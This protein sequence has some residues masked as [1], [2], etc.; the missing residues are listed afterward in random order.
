[1]IQGTYHSRMGKVMR[2]VRKGTDMNRWSNRGNR[3]SNTWAIGIIVSGG[4]LLL[5]SCGSSTSTASTNS[6]PAQGA[7]PVRG[8]TI[9]V[10][11]VSDPPT[12]DWTSSTSTITYEVAWNIFE[13]LFAL[14]KNSN[15]KPMLATGYT[16][17][18]NGMN[19]TIGIRKGITFQ[20]GQSL[21]SADVVAS[22]KR[23]EAISSV[24]ET[25]A[26][27][28]ASVSAAGKYQVD[29]AMSTPFSPL[30]LD[31]AAPAQACIIIPASIVAAAGANPLTNAQIIGTGPYKLVNDLVGQKIELTRWSGY[32]PLPKADNWGGLAGYKAAYATN[33]NYDIVPSPATR[34][35]GLLTGQFQLADTLTSQDYSQL[36]G[37]SSVKPLLLPPSNQLMIVFNKSLSPFNNLKM[38]EAINLVSNKQNIAAAAFGQKRFWTLSDALFQ[39]TQTSLYT[40]AGSK[41][42]NAY[43]P[44][45]AKKL[46]TQAGYNFS[47]PIRILVTQTY[48]YMYNA[49]VALSEELNQIG[50]KTSVLSYDWPTDLAMRKNPAAWDIFITA[51]SPLFDP[52]QL[53]W[54]SPTYNGWYASPQMQSLM[55]NWAASTTKA[56]QA[57]L[58]TQIQSLEWAQLPIVKI[59]NQ[60]ALNG[61]RS[62]LH[63]YQ[64]IAG[65]D[66]LWN[67]WIS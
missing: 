17:S 31:L 48:P 41:Q 49:G 22:I 52:T 29:I 64:T 28:V 57:K 66:I 19:Y 34:L 10:A 36:T 16:E 14:D 1:M 9:N 63:G 7:K 33:L 50:V 58:V 32:K 6:T 20:N 24:G 30:I 5:A 42:Y 37:S 55:A 3:R 61:E 8:G 2:I 39:P 47:R 35:S 15:P 43:S 27:H 53:L 67:T 38:R 13:Q 46:M 21:T 40:T 26:T 45:E 44:S 25:V 56:Q 65:S 60:R 11:V 54:L 59:A 12:L 18:A 23:W 4:A 51:F 62:T